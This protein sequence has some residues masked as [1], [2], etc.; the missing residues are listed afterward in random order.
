MSLAWASSAFRFLRDKVDYIEQL[1]QSNQEQN[2]AHKA[3]TALVTAWVNAPAG[4]PVIGDTFALKLSDLTTL[5]DE[6]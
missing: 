1:N 4:V 3:A 5:A 2:P 6:W